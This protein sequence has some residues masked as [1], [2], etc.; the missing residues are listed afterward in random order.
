MLKIIR[1]YVSK[2]WERSSL[3]LFLGRMTNCYYTLGKC[4]WEAKQKK[5]FSLDDN[6]LGI[7]F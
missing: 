4:F 6:E 5:V 7:I 2:N 1:A 3:F